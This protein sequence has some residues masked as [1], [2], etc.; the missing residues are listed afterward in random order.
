MNESFFI[1]T[2]K[3]TKSPYWRFEIRGEKIYYVENNNCNSIKKMKKINAKK[4]VQ[5]KLKNK[6]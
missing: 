5:F 1:K 4:W 3:K 2:I 6:I